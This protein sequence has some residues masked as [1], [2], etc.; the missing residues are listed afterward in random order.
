MSQWEKDL[1]A[2]RGEIADVRQ[3]EAT[4][5]TDA[6]RTEQS[7]RDA[8]GG[9]VPAEHFDAV[10]AAYRG[11]DAMRDRAAELGLREQ[12]ILKRMSVDTGRPQAGLIPTGDTRDRGD[13]AARVAKHESIERL[14]GRYEASHNAPLGHSDPIENVITRDEMTGGG[15]FR[16]VSSWFDVTQSAGLHVP[17]YRD[18]IVEQLVRKVT[19]LDLLSSGT[20]DTDVVNWIV[21]SAR[22]EGSVVPAAYGTAAGIANYAF[23]RQSAT[24]KRIPGMVVSDKGTLADAGQTETL[25]NQRLLN[26]LRRTTES[27][28]WTGSGTGDNLTGITNATYSASFNTLNAAG[29]TAFDAVHKAITA[30]RVNTL[31]NLDPTTLLISPNDYEV[32]ILAKDDMGRYLISDPVADTRRPIWGLVPVVTPLISDGAPFV[33][34]LKTAAT[35]YLRAGVSVSVSDQHEDFFARGLVGWLAELRVAL[36][37]QQPK[38]ITA[39]SNFNA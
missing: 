23:T 18:T 33:C 11:A 21:E 32:L 20:T 30:Q 38:A 36:A 3:Q 8:N 37:V 29:L 7:I 1:K 31:L 6:Q 17:D 4:S 34:D 2:V 25:L 26:V 22:S 9:L 10:D 35:L 24:V 13:F 16:T 39:V 12:Q 15:R 19:L 28:V 14:R 27:Q 5:R